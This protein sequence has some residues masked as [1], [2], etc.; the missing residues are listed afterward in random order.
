MDKKRYTLKE[1]RKMNRT[2]AHDIASYLGISR[3]HY[4]R[5]ENKQAVF[6]NEYKIR[7]ASLYNLCVTDIEF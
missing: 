1:V 6:S 5:L 3:T 4:Y 2:K 7:L